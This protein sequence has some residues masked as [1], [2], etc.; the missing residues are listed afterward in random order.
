MSYSSTLQ[1]HTLFRPE[2]E[3]GYTALVPSLPGCIS[4]G[5]TLEEA[6]EMIADAIEGYL[7]SLQKH[8]ESIPTDADALLGMTKVRTGTRVRHRAKAYG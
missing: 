3:G 4:Y 8:N 5:E 1:F 2:P 7:V 6:K